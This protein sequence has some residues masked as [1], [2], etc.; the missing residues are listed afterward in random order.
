MLDTEI[1][2]IRAIENLEGRANRVSMTFTLP[3][4]TGKTCIFG[5]NSPIENMEE[6]N[7]R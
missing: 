3:L 2:V 7:G 5:I 1:N 6:Y 4:K